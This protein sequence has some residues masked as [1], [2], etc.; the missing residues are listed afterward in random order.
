MIKRYGSPP[1]SGTK[2]VSRP[3]IYAILPLG[4]QL[5]L[6][7]QMEPGP[8]FQLPGGGID[9]GEHPISALYREVMEETGWRIARPRRV[10]VLG[11]EIVQPLA[12]HRVALGLLDARPQS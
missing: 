8:E 7:H 5:L 12:Q 2:Y 1:R 9:P 6:T 4:N 11:D 3:G 10:D